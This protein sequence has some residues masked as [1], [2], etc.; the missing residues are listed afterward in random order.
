MYAPTKRVSQEK[1]KAIE[2]FHKGLE[3]Y[4]K[5]EWEDAIKYF[6]EA[7]KIDSNDGPSKTF[8]ERCKYYKENDPGEGW[9]GV[10]TMTTK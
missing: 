1:L 6:E 4:R 8:L 10:F 2:L 5:R 7:I 3:L 9:D